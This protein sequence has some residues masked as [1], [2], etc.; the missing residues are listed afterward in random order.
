MRS[1]EYIYI[2]NYGSTSLYSTLKGTS[3]AKYVPYLM[4]QLDDWV[5]QAVLSYF[6]SGGYAGMRLEQ[7]LCLLRES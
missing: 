7:Y 3:Y 1:D 4:I 5:V 2:P 6:K